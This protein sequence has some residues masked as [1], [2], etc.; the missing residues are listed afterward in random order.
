MYY[1]YKDNLEKAK[2]ILRQAEAE[3]IH[4]GGIAAAKSALLAKVGSL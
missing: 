4:P 2:A 1:L 3:Q